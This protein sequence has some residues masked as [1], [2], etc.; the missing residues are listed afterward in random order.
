MAEAFVYVEHPIALGLGP[1]DEEQGLEVLRASE[2]TRAR[3]EPGGGSRTA[4]SRSIGPSL[5]RTHSSKARAQG[6]GLL[7][8]LGERQTMQVVDDAARANEHDVSKAERRQGP[9]KPE[10]VCR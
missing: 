9:A 5:R 4:P 6:S 3:E 1:H 7:M 10:E 8:L 2:P